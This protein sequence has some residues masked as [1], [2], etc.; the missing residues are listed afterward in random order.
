M[1]VDALSKSMS[2]DER[3]VA[4]AAPRTSPKPILGASR[5]IVTGSRDKNQGLRT[6]SAV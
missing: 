4:A 3:K 1:R 2:I 6:T 5:A